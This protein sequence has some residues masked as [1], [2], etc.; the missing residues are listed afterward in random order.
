MFEWLFYLHW[1]HVISDD[2]EFSF[3]SNYFI[4]T[5]IRLNKFKLRDGP[6]GLFQIHLFILCR[7]V[8]TKWLNLL[9]KIC[10]IFA[11]IFFLRTFALFLRMKRNEFCAVLRYF[12]CAICAKPEIFFAKCCARNEILVLRIFFAQFAQNRKFYAKCNFL[13]KLSKIDI[14]SLE[15]N[16]WRFIAYHKEKY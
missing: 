5:S 9:R 1:F 3:Q 8:S 12:F 2:P 10:A 13:G 7:R 6:V 11:Q 14:L 4:F 15:L 16:N